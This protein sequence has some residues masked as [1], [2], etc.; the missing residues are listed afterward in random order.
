MTPTAPSLF[1]NR[2]LVFTG[3]TLLVVFWETA[4]VA[5]A[6]ATFRACAHARRPARDYAASLV[7]FA[8][9]VV[10]AAVIPPVL[11]WQTTETTPSFALIG[12]AREMSLAVTGLD[13]TS[14]RNLLRRP[15]IDGCA[16]AVALVWAAGTLVLAVRFGGGWLF[17]RNIAS[18]ARPIDDP[19]LES[20]IRE[21]AR[22]GGV[23]RTI[24][25]LEWPAVDTPVV[26]GWRNP[27]LFLPPAAVLQLSHQQL[28]GVI[29]H[30]VAHIRRGDYVINL[31]QS[32]A[33][34]PLFFSPAVAWMSRCIREA[35]EFCCDDE[36]AARVGNKRHYVEAL[37]HLAARPTTSGVRSAVGI[38][39]PRL[40]TR[41][42]RL[43]QEDTMPRL[44]RF[45]LI[46]LGVAFVLIVLS[47]LQLS[48]A[49]ALRFSRQSSVYNISDP[50]VKAPVV[51]REVKPQYTDD[52]KSRKVQGSVELEEVITSD[53]SVRE[54]VRVVKSLD[55]D[56]DAQAVTAAKQW[57]FKPGTK[58][59]KP[60]DVL[61]RIEMTFTL[62]QHA[63]K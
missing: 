2:Y 56:L 21:L 46:P 25:L 40:V 14:L 12:S 49:S 18:G 42:R 60:V 27:R 33:E 24:R 15:L 55:P 57:Q 54:D 1:T 8:G 11:A 58:D 5:V 3:W 48:A 19:A 6:L 63:R 16:A 28:A 13:I 45:R 7:A 31:L 30:E 53:G 43:L 32:A 52:A 26:V 20:M 51:V 9:S 50:G 38:A 47:G 37:T 39:G 59:G 4:A 35:R 44:N 41:V 62:K 23:T 61:V 36:A 10:I 17:A 22:C 29:A 34:V